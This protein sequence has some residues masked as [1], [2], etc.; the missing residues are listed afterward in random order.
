MNKEKIVWGLILLG[1]GLIL[2]LNNMDVIDFHWRAVFRMWPLIIIVVGLNLLLSRSALGKTISI[3]VTIAC[4]AFLAYVGISSENVRGWG[5]RGGDWGVSSRSDGGDRGR[6]AKNVI[7]H[8]YDGLVKSAKLNIKGGAVEYDIDSPD[9]NH[10]FWSETESV[11]GG[12]E[13]K[14]VESNDSSITLSFVM[15]ERLEKKDWNFRNDKNEAKIRLHPDPVWIIDMEMGA[16]TADF[17]L[18]E[19]KISRL[20]MDC[21]AASVEVKLGP[22]VGHSEVRADIGAASLEIEVPESASCRIVTSSAL[23]SRDFKGFVKQ[24]DGSYITPGY[25]GQGDRYTL[26]LKGGVSSFTVKRKPD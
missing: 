4:I 22:P 21:G 8:E 23:S 13:L 5:L 10:L 16:G 26:H 6:I 9:E 17:D 15:K 25:N 3:L 12:H 18:R 24:E 7:T 19:Y 1:V 20:E 2:L 11:V 14:A